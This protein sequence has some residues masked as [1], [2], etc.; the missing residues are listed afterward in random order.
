MLLSPL[1]FSLILNIIWM[2]LSRRYLKFSKHI[3][4]DYPFSVDIIKEI[5]SPILSF[6]FFTVCIHLHIFMCYW[7]TNIYSFLANLSECF[8]CKNIFFWCFWC[9]ILNML[10]IFYIHS[11]ENVQNK[12]IKGSLDRKV[13]RTQAVQ[14]NVTMNQDSIYYIVINE[15]GEY[16]RHWPTSVCHVKSLSVVV[17]EPRNSY[18]AIFKESQVSAELLEWGKTAQR[19]GCHQ[20]QTASAHCFSPDKVLNSWS[21]LLCKSLCMIIVTVNVHVHFLYS[22]MS[23]SPPEGIPCMFHRL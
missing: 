5:F 3:L 18:F 14:F 16:H 7:F 2:L 12:H 17:R 20:Y 4:R 9:S 11:G 15:A 21:K 8:C 19:N 13:N 6:Q 10:F 1:L 22:R 23:A